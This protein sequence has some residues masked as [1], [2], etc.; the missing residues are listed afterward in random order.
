MPEDILRG[1]EQERNEAAAADAEQR[2]GMAAALRETISQPLEVWEKRG[3]LQAMAVLGGLCVLGLG[4]AQAAG[5][6]STPPEYPYMPWLC[7]VAGAVALAIGIYGLTRRGPLLR[8]TAQALESRAYDPI[9]WEAIRDYEIEERFARMVLILTLEPGI[10]LRRRELAPLIVM[11]K[12]R[13]NRAAI[14]GE[15][16]RDYTWDTV[17]ERLDACLA[18]ARLRD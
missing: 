6:V 18:A 10:Q 17:L 12:Y 2:R 7:M 5:A 15:C 14:A 3:P 9:P 13:G 1:L 8:L 16:L 4:L 11:L